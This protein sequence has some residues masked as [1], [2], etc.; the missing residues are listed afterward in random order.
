M[1]FAITLSSY[2]KTTLGPLDTLAA[3]RGFFA[4]TTCS[5]RKLTMP[6]DYR[7]VLLSISLI[8][9]PRRNLQTDGVVIIVLP[10]NYSEYFIFGPSGL[11]I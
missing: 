2:T 1:L 7:F 10:C 5:S 3:V 4:D 11:S 6:L 8:S 9:A